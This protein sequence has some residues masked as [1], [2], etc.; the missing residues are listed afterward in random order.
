MTTQE[1]TD[2]AAKRFSEQAIVTDAWAADRGYVI[3]V[4]SRPMM[5]QGS[6]FPLLDLAKLLDMDGEVR[7]VTD[8]THNGR[9]RDAVH[10][11][12]VD[13]TTVAR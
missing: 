13:R 8:F 7:V 11:E 2:A 1:H 4:L 9:E 12:H 10:F 3:A 6:I 5:N